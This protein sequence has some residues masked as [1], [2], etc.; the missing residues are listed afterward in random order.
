M[1]SLVI[2]LRF[3]CYYV[4]HTKFITYRSALASLCVGITECL[5]AANYYILIIMTIEIKADKLQEIIQK[6]INFILK[7]RTG[8][9]YYA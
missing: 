2:P 6:Y 3:S 7:S 8:L 4:M 5:H 9:Q 1:I